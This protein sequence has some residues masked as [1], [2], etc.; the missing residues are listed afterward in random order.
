MAADMQHAHQ[1][2]N[3]LGPGQLAAVVHVMETM[4]SPR[5]METP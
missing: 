2:L 1:L 3:Q 4:V 5:R